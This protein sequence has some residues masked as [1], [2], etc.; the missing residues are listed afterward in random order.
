MVHHSDAHFTLKRVIKVE[1]QI[2]NHALTPVRHHEP[3]TINQSRWILIG[4]EEFRIAE[5]PTGEI[6]EGRLIKDALATI[7]SDIKET[8]VGITTHNGEITERTSQILQTP[9]MPALIVEK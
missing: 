7:L 4:H 9:A 5:R 3:T 6:S 1:I 2:S 8:E